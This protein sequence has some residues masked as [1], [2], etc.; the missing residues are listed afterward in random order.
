MSGAI[1]QE[2]EAFL[3]M[4]EE[5]SHSI[6]SLPAGELMAHLSDAAAALGERRYAELLKSEQFGILRDASIH[7][8]QLRALADI[9]ARAGAYTPDEAAIRRM[10]ELA[11]GEGANGHD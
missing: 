2:V 5:A 10:L 8:D 11:D 7:A 6:E 1:S 4:W 9:R 3:A